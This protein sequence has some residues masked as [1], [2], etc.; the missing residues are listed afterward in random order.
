MNFWFKENEEYDITLLR[1]MLCEHS[2]CNVNQF[3]SAFGT[4][5]LHAIFSSDLA[6]I[7]DGKTQ[8]RMSAGKADTLN[9][10]ISTKRKRISLTT[11]EP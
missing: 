2:V 7:C 8:D 1:E 4:N 11:A 6:H 10:A 5:D 9:D 3:I